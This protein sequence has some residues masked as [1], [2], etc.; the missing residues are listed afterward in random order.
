MKTLGLVAAALL[1]A[2][3]QAP[4]KADPAEQT[5][6]EMCNALDRT[7][8]FSQKFEATLSIGESGVGGKLAGVFRT[9]GSSQCL[10]EVKGETVLGP[11]DLRT[12]ASGTGLKINGRIGEA[13]PDFTLP[14]LPG[15][16]WVFA[17]DQARIGCS[18]MVVA[19]L[20]GALNPMGALHPDH[21]TRAEG[22]KLGTR[23]TV[24]G[25]AAT[26]LEYVVGPENGEGPKY[27]VKAWLDPR[28]SAPVKRIVKV[29][30]LGQEITIEEVYTDVVFGLPLDE[31]QFE[32]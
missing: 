2:P 23:S 24:A 19:L 9:R 21:F 3:P 27:R 18:G 8:S 29:A 31:K 13:S 11:I 1:A 10:F 32:E 26:V 16:A 28:T 7:K 30:T 17:A 14:I 15:L 6:L 4:K 12:R 5:F 20:G 22:F 25:Q